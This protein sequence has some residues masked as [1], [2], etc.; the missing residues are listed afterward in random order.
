MRL[1]NVLSTL[2]WFPCPLV[3]GFWDFGTS[4][5]SW[6][7]W[8]AD[9]TARQS[10]FRWQKS[11]S[12]SF[13]FYFPWWNW[14][15]LEFRRRLYCVCGISYEMLNLSTGALLNRRT[16]LTAANC[17]EP[18]IK[19]PLMLR[20][21]ALGNKGEHITPFRYRAWRVT[22]MYPRSVNPE[23]Q[24]GPFAYHSP[25]H[26]VSVIHTRDQMYI[27][28]KISWRYHY[29]YRAFL[30]T[31]TMIYLSDL[32][33][34]VGSGY[35]YLEHIYENYKIFF[36]HLSKS[37]VRDCSELLPKWWGK[38]I[39]MTNTLSLPGVQNG[40]GL[41]D[42][43]VVIGLGC[44]EI[45][46]NEDKMFVFTDLRYYVLAIYALAHIEPGEYYE[47]AYPQWSVQTGW[48]GMFDWSGNNPYI[49]SWQI[50]NDM[51]PMGK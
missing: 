7:T 32:Q 51:Y 33:F 39:C 34:M 29:P 10:R 11:E 25:R 40:G 15:E 27:T 50:K 36:T 16:V 48:F 5:I 8:R 2:L 37:I 19:D 9:W 47:Y 35:E 6:S 26:D 13:R 24:H 30:P 17:L 31:Y 41:Y 45:R 4:T 46:Y 22:R 3:F 44:F 18:Y 42:Y 14:Y 43:H 20:I 28:S 38:F 21:W 1:S 12:D 49:P 23:H